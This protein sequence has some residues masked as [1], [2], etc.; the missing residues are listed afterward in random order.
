[1]SAKKIVLTG[2]IAFSFCLLCK[3]KG[4]IKTCF[5][6]DLQLNKILWKLCI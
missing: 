5:P 1:M 6:T 2:F 4:K 3:C